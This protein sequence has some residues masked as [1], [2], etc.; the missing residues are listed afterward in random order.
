MNIAKLI[1]LSTIAATTAA[2]SVRAD[3]PNVILIMADDIG[4]EGIGCY[5]GTSYATP[6][7]DR[8]AANG[9][10]FTHAYSQPL[11]TNTRVQLMTGLFNNRNWLYFGILDRKAKTIGHYMREAGYQTCIAGKWQLQSYD[12]T[13]Y[14]GAN[15]R[16]GN[17]MKVANAGFDE[18]NLFHSWHT[19]DKGSRYANPTTFENGKLRDNLKEQYGPDVWVEFIIDYIKRKKDD[20]KPFFVYYPMALPH[21]PFQPTPKSKAWSDSANRLKEDPRH[22]KDMVEYMDKCVGRIVDQVDELGLG[23]NTL[24]LFYGDN[25]THKSITSQTKTGPVTGGKGSTTDAG[26]HVPL[27][28]R[29]T[30]RIKPGIDEDLADSTDFLPTIMDAATRPIPDD[31]T[32]DG[33]SFFP[34]LV[35]K[36]GPS[37]PWVFC[38]YDPRPGWDKDQFKKVRFVRDK[39]HKLY[40]DGRLF[41]VSNDKLEQHP[42]LAADDTKHTKTVRRRLA[43]VLED[44]PNPD[45]APRELAATKDA[46]QRLYLAAG[47]QLTT[48]R[49]DGN[50]GNLKVVQNLPLAGAGPFTF[51]PNRQRMYA[52]AASTKKATKTPAIATLDI[53]KDGSLKL[54]HIAPVNLRPG[55]LKT[56]S[57][58]AYLAGNHYGPGK[59]TIWAIEKGIYQGLTVTELTLEKN[60]HCARFSP[61]NQWLLVPA[62]GPNKVFVNRFD[63]QTGAARPNTPPFASGPS[64]DQDAQQP[65]HLIFHPTKNL[66]YTTNERKHAG[67]GVWNWDA[68]KGQLKPVQN[69]VTEPKGFKGTITTADLHMTS[70][71][72]FLYISNRDTTKRDATTGSNSIVGFRIDPSSGHLTFIGHYPC[73]G[74]P[75]S[76]AIDATDR[77]VFVAGQ[78]DDRLGVFKINTTTGALTKINQYQTGSRPIWVESLLLSQ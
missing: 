26:T 78:R 60:A 34:R 35:G 45:P 74:V 66:V 31:V 70:D 23:K 7:I 5:G 36:P 2:P 52:V 12:P 62:T 57:N 47:N 53:Q 76:F 64:G 68:K 46:E 58:G 77:F 38:H 67:V 24:I 39:N 40:G 9:I 6:A 10:R 8:M 49:I 11:C 20:D 55:Y 48:Y 37:R 22:F 56:D 19:E 30:G 13:D 27:V 25:G 75:R 51:S 61:D 44:M 59:A 32:I 29:W 4:V 28:A 18:F 63:A 33:L 16:R 73:E 65:R 43:V 21:R 15:L 50:S 42:I 3:R 69:V 17:G 1:L 54:A 41:N 72:R 14:P 71:A